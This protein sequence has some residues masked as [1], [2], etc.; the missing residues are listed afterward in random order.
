MYY[1]STETAKA[2]MLYGIPSGNIFY[3]HRFG[4][5][6]CEKW[7]HSHEQMVKFLEAHRFQKESALKEKMK[8]E[9]VYGPK[10]ISAFGEVE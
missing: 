4:D 1:T 9:S 3:G 7:L 2:K 6:L 8:V 5:V 10:R